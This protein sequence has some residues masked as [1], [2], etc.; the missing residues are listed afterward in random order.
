MIHLV[1]SN[2]TEDLLAA[3]ATAVAGVR[4]ESSLFEAVTIVVPNRNVEAYLKQ[5]LAEEL[6]IAANLRICFLAPLVRDLMRDASPGIRVIDRELLE[7][8]V[9][10][11][12]LDPSAMAHP[13]LEPAR[14]W[15]SASGE[16]PA[17]MDKRRF[18][19]ALQLARLFDEYAGSRPDWLDAWSTRLNFNNGPARELESW[20][21]RVW[22][23]VQARLREREKDEEVSYR[24]LRDVFRG[25]SAEPL[26]V[27][28]NLFVFGFSY[29]PPAYHAFFETI[30]HASAVTLFTLNP[31]RQYWE[32]VHQADD[33]EEMPLLRQW[34]R[35]G[36]VHVATLNS[37]SAH[38]TYELYSAPAPNTL[39]AS[40]QRDVLERAANKPSEASRDLDDSI[41]LTACPSMRREAEEVAAQ[42]W[43]AL[44]ESTTSDRPLRFHE[45]GVF[46]NPSER[47][48]YLSH[49][50]SAFRDNHGIPHHVVDLPL[51]MESRLVEAVTLLLGLPN[52]RF[53][54]AEM[55]KLLT[56][57]AFASR[58]P[59]I[60]V[61]RWVELVDALGIMHGADHRD[62]AGT[63]IESDSFNWDQGLKRI[64]LGAFMDADEDSPPFVQG[65]QSYAPFSLPDS[66]RENAALL[67]SS[68]R[69]LLA[70]V[71]RATSAKLTMQEWAQFLGDFVK[72]HLSA[73]EEADAR[74]L[75]ICLAAIEDLTDIEMDGTPVSFRIAHDFAV[76]KLAEI[77]AR[78][79]PFLEGGVVVS[80]FF[81]M[82]AIP[83]RVVFALGLGE[84]KFPS[85][86]ITNPLDLRS[87]A[88]HP[89]D[90]SQRAQDKYL[91]LETLLC[92][93]DKL[94]LSYVA[95]N[96]ITGDPLEPSV[97][98]R[99][100]M[101]Y[102]HTR[103]GVQEREA[104]VV[105][106]RRFD[107]RNVD[108]A[109]LLPDEAHREA[110]AARLSAAA[111]LRMHGPVSLA[112]VREALTA[113]ARARLDAA[114]GV[115]AR[116]TS[117]TSVRERVRVSIS[118]LRQFL[119]CQVQGYA[120]FH[121]GDRDDESE[122][123]IATLENEPFE[124]KPY[125]RVP[126]LRR[127]WIDALTLNVA[128]L[129]FVEDRAAR[130]ARRGEWPEGVFARA[131]L[132]RANE[133][134]NDWT[135]AVARDAKLSS[136]TYRTH[137]FGPVEESDKT[138]IAH[139]SFV[140][141]LPTNADGMTREVELVGR[142]NS[143]D[144]L[145]ATY[146]HLVTTSS[147]DSAKLARYKTEAAL[148]LTLESAL[149]AAVTGSSPETASFAIV[150]ACDKPTSVTA[151]VPGWNSENARAWLQNVLSDLLGDA[152][153]SLLP[154]EA[155]FK[156]AASRTPIRLADTVA[157][158][159]DAFDAGEEQAA[160]F[161]FAKGPVRRVS[162]LPVLD[163]ESLQQLVARR[164]EPVLARRLEGKDK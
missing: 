153:K 159:L 142:I 162:E 133:V 115:H 156:S 132:E 53:G 28:A 131:E 141:S 64:A 105:P 130:L 147:V 25:L 74:D 57:P 12:L 104:V 164:L 161:S 27:P 3:L 2:R 6:G 111:R 15:I 30:A 89:A 151:A 126:F 33:P 84:G 36:R 135:K 125:V 97:L 43:E 18:Q 158:M 46:I 50:T 124:L 80:S 160:R 85:P 45:I 128:P 122:E 93:R 143:M 55:L 81:P 144:E 82:R 54:R 1:Y 137:V 91:F 11:V 152:P 140:I 32:D 26:N 134:L 107:S 90:V 66:L 118:A 44:E 157:D 56:H 148:R 29:F 62:H 119:E 108:S 149:F 10:A 71:R 9:L 13:D 88:P 23:L 4:K 20:Q 138:S 110:F 79:G 59:S 42:I 145:S 21:R 87:F 58:Y 96:E 99:D 129:S 16:T 51:A 98:V 155:A 35:P 106:L 14:A 49:L 61:S 83:F 86:E 127:T 150:I 68:V 7:G 19:L 37:L 63:Y 136:G 24:L 60:E 38:H 100:L 102:L 154:Y 139:P 146:L 40:V 117:T 52:G 72:T 94:A 73:P 92:A 103:Y 67:A 76:G 41:T 70:D 22:L 75:K 121:F 77:G 109:R 123:D 112:K 114:L 69:A 34:G 8:Q 48:A 113:D 5:G 65:S 95:R 78:R 47:D 163:E 120:K 116:H 101:G 31:C 39:L 17:A